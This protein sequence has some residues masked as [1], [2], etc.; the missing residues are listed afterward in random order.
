M[1]SEKIKEIWK[2]NV[3][4]QIDNYTDAEIEAMILKNARKAIG[5]SY[6]GIVF[7]SFAIVLILFLMWIDLKY[8]PQMRPFWMVCLVILFGSICITIFSRWKIQRY[9]YDMPLKDWI[10]SRIREFDKSINL[11]KIYWIALTYGVSFIILVIYDVFL[12][13]IADFTI[14]QIVI[15]F[16]VG[17]ICMIGFTKFGNRIIMKRMMKTRKRLQELY[18][19][20]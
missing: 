6:P 18:D 2:N 10:E 17:F 20:L 5:I 12:V 13:L 4:R 7:I 14:L 3:V 11:K 15:S 8:T 16:T 1:D 19:Q 9:S